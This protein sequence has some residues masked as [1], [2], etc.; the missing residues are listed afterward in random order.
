[1]KV[2]S[3]SNGVYVGEINSRILVKIGF[4]E[5][6]PAA[7]WEVL[8]EGKGFA[9]W[10][11]VSLRYSIKRRELLLVVYINGEIFGS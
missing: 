10:K 2:E 4:G 7:D 1:M 6:T 8:L 9:V 3:G 5:Y 11:K